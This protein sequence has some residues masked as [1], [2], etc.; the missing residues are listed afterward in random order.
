MIAESLHYLYDDD[1]RLRTVLI[2]G[3][4]LIFG[5]LLLPLFLVMGYA[6]R[7]IRRTATGDETVPGFDDWG[8]LAV[9]GAKAFVIQFVYGAVPAALAAAFVGVAVLGA[10]SGGEGG[11]AV[12]GLVAAVGGLLA[13]VLGLVAAYLAPA[14]V[15]NFAAKGTLGA[16]FAVADLRRVWTSPI[17]ARAWLAGAAI[18]LG[19]GVVAGVLGVVPVLGQVVAAFVT[20]Y[21][22][23]AAYYIIGHAWADL[24]GIEMRTDEGD[25]DERPA[26]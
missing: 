5:W 15:A 9:T 2:G 23:V 14:A 22:V 18:V 20:F 7:V 6:V 11:A 25:V 24:G 13:V 3:V 16:G 12:G 26:V 1:D 10:A 21:A 17:Y 8:D 19:A 4:L